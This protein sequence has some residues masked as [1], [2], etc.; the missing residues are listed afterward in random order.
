MTVL[1]K[2]GVA[3]GAGLAS[4]LLFAA[5]QKDMPLAFALAYLAPL[6]TMIVALGWGLTA[7]AVAVLASGGAAAVVID[8]LSGLI[9][10]LTVALP[11][12]I[13]A[14]LARLD[15][16]NP[17]D[18]SSPPA[19]PKRLGLGVIALAA[20]GLGFVVSAGAMAAMLLAYGG[21]D[22]AVAAFGDL[23]KRSLDEAT[24]SGVAFPEGFSV[25]DVGR[26]IVRFAPAAI[27]ASTALMLIANL[28]A[29]ARITQ[30]SQRLERPWID[31]PYGYRLPA[32]AGLVTL[33]ALVGAYFLPAP[34]EPFVAALAAPLALVFLMQGLATLHALSRRAPG[35]PAL[36]AALYFALFFAPYWVGPALIVIGLAESALRLRRRVSLFA[37][38]KPNPNVES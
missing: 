32:S 2:I 6:P 4:A 29:A 16:L 34:Y 9:F 3:L 25:E 24:A 15:R 20:A 5:I 31:V 23:L 10:V 21:H 30:V 14:A 27:A 18:R 33:A 26:L 1:N 11:A 13:V 12:G 28:Y 8:P 36:I 19:N 17:F 37:A 7:D 22:A 38:K 35:R